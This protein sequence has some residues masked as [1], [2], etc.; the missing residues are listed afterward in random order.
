MNIRKQGTRLQRRCGIW[1]RKHT[2]HKY[3]EV[4]ELAE[5]K[6]STLRMGFRLFDL[7][8]SHVNPLLFFPLSIGNR[9]EKST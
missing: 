5:E 6:L 2:T 9:K 8:Q 1:Y 4:Q 7:Q 3:Y